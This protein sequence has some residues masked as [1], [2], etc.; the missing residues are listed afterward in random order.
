[1]PTALRIIT[2]ERII[3]DGEVDQVTIPTQSGEITVLPQHVGLVGLLKSGELTIKKDGEIIPMVVSTGMLEVQNTQI[4][5]L[6]DTAERVEE[7]IEE[8]AQEAH[9]RAAELLTQQA[10]DTTEYAIIAAKLEKELARL[11]V[12]RK[13]RKNTA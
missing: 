12:V 2:P 10:F 3:Y 13:H 1:M 5:I 11:H 7:I 8:R 4:I 6:A 9:R